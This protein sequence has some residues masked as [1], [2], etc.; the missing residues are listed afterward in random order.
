MPLRRISTS[1]LGVYG[2]LVCVDAT[3]PAS[4]VR[5]KRKE[6]DKTARL[7]LWQHRIPCPRYGRLKLCTHLFSTEELSNV[8]ELYAFLSSS[9]HSDTFSIV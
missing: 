1:F 9:K 6:A 2:T 5:D 7:A 4:A 8:M 3:I